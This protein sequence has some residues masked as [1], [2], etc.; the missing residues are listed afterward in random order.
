MDRREILKSA[1]AAFVATSIGTSMPLRQSYARA[2][3]GRAAVFPLTAVHLLDSDFRAAQ[4]RNARYLRSLDADRLLHNFRVNAG[5]K[6]KAPVY[7][8]WESQEPWIDIR[9]HGHTLGHYLSACAMHY[10]ATGEAAFKERV[11]Y[12]VDELAECQKAAKSGLVCAFPDGATQLER[13]LRG[14][15]FV[16]VPWYTMHKIFAGLR[17][18]HVHANSARALEVLI[19]LCEWAREATAPLSDEAM[20]KMLDREHGGM[21]EIFADVHALTG[22]DAYL[23]LARRFSH[24][25]LL[26][27]LVEGRDVLDGL[28]SN[29]QIPKV[30]GFARL[31]ELTGEEEYRRAARFFWERVVRARSFVT[32]GNGDGEHFFPPHEFAQRLGSA[33]T[34]ETCC[35][36]NL[37]KLTRK[38]FQDDPAASY[39]DYYERALYNGI[40]AS[41]D[42]DSGM[43][44]YFQA[45]RPGYVK[46]YCTPFDSFWCCTG[47]GIENHAK[48]GDSIYFHDDRSLY[49][50]LFIPSRLDWSERGL[51]LTQTTDFPRADR[52][53]ISFEL[54]KPSWLAVR[55]RH[56]A[57]CREATVTLNGKHRITSKQSGS[58]M[59]VER[60][61]R[62]GD[63]LEVHV[64]MH[65]HTEPLPSEPSFQAV[66]YGPIVLVGRMGTHGLSPGADL[67]VNERL[68]GTMLNDPTP[69][70]AWRGSPAKFL[71]SFASTG[72]PLHFSAT[73]FEDG[74]TIEFMP[75]FALAHERYNL[76]WRLSSA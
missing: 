51:A 13:S 38:L 56:P 47:S 65:L 69:V 6:P 70:P 33:K 27:P 1:A 50:N 14:E 18:A 34:M 10:A 22:D 24:R 43:V 58:Y 49:V 68:S 19:K 39:A 40:L 60:Q 3:A 11:D 72:T 59:N 30:I 73:G 44:T 25:A 57:W 74:R 76:Y 63:T 41:Q 42:P 12:V 31:Y 29:T 67:I 53:R 46:L 37:L 16:G 15:T 2:D 17:D 5:L 61:W 48:Y 62:S 54:R 4:E 66:L 35:T 8:G 75:Y 32:G 26:T 23:H 64:P 36:H 20:Q 55:I 45:T 28:H 52:S 7:G 21:N 71:D 9:C